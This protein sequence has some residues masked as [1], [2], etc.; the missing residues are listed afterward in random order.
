[1]AEFIG[2]QILVTYF[3]DAFTVIGFLWP[4]G[5]R[6]S[7]KT[8]L[9]IVVTELAYLGETILAGG[10]YAC[11]RDLADYGATLAFDDAENLSDPK[12]TDPDK[13]ALLLAGNRKGNTVPVKEAG[14]S[15]TW[16]TRHVN[17]FCPRLF[18][19]I[20]LPDSVLA[21]RSIVVPLIRTPDPYRANADPLDYTIWP[22]DRGKL[23]DDLW[24]MAL[25]NLP[26]MPA[27]VAQINRVAQLSGRNLEPWRPILAVARWLED[28]GV[29]GIFARME[30]LSHAYQTERPDLESADLQVLVI[31][32]LCHYATKST[33]ATNAEGGQSGFAKLQIFKR[34][35]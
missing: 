27:Y 31:K 3:L 4:N 14:P 21:S 17:T 19:A 9:L 6:G 23:K 2:C 10:S 24:A 15:G 33:S 11:L 1:M 16:H 26:E 34:L 7:G 5:D 35:S 32:A 22:H 13:R 29:D 18:S 25:A 30:A 28:T 8:Q 12:R 20:H